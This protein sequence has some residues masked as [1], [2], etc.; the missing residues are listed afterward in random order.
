MKPLLLVALLCA[1][2]LAAPID[3]ALGGR[4]HAVSAEDVRALGPHADRVLIGVASDARVS[5]LRRARALL[6]LRFAPSD[7]SREFL[8]AV[9]ADKRACVEGADVLDLSAAITS[10]S[11]YGR[12]VLADVLP[13]AAH[14]SADVR[15]ATV[16]VLGAMQAPEAQSALR[17]RLF[18]ER[19]PGVRDAAARALK[20]AQP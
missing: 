7:E 10:L 15:H 13:F 18:V 8:R 12:E 5:R 17:A 19:D 11:P 20:P 6:A 4:E 2:A 9:I 1:P 3:R 14:A 16:V